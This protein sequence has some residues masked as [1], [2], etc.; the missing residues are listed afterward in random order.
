MLLLSITAVVRRMVFVFAR[1][2]I[3]W[4]AGLC[5]GHGSCASCRPFNQ[6]VEFTPVKPNAPTLGA[7][8]DFNALAFG[9]QEVGIRADRAFHRVPSVEVEVSTRCWSRPVFG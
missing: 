9:H 7:I 4:V 1:V 5:N 2:P 8:V 6:F 3:G